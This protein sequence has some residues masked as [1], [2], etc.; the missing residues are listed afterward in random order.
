VRRPDRR[1]RVGGPGVGVQYGSRP[2]A[3][4]RFQGEQGFGA[5]C[6][7][8]PRSPGPSHSSRNQVFGLNGALVRHTA[9]ASASS[10]GSVRLTQ[11]KI[12]PVPSQQHPGMNRRD[13]CAQ[14]LAWSSGALVGTDPFHAAIH[15]FS[16]HRV[17]AGSGAPVLLRP[18]RRRRWNRLAAARQGCRCGDRPR[19]RRPYFGHWCR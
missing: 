5:G 10:N 3:P 11:L 7:P 2:R 16:L 8:W 18:A 6:P 17:N 13:D 4:D 19:R 12:P 15:L 9:G 1:A 14:A